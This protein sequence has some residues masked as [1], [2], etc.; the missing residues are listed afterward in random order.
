MPPTPGESPTLQPGSCFL[1]PRLQCP[2]KAISR[3]VLAGACLVLVVCPCL[4][5]I[6]QPPATLV[7]QNEASWSAKGLGHTVPQSRWGHACT[8]AG[9]L[10]LHMCEVA[11]VQVC[12]RSSQM[13][14]P[15][16]GRAG[17]DSPG[18]FLSS[19]QAEAALFTCI[20]NLW[21]LGAASSGTPHLCK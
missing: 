7:P 8:R 15:G 11:P 2:H 16:E 13:C 1:L 20:S 10:P 21:L 17:Q 3:L 19:A 5:V 14:T 9:A 12:V 6:L 18:H 4:S